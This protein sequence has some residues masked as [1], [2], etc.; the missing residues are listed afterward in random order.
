MKFKKIKSLSLIIIGALFLAGCHTSELSE[1]FETDVVVYK[2]PNCGCCGQHSA[3]M[4]DEGF[5]VDILLTEDME[6]IKQKYNIP[7]EMQ[8][9]HTAIV[10]DYFVE[11][12]MPIEAIVKLLEEKPSVDGIALP[13]M[14][15]GSPGMPGPK[16]EPFTIH[17]LVDGEASIYTV[18]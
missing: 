16:L 17:Q 4:E 14:P 2:S 3:Y 18:L 9:C 11:G 13:A 1:K 7:R 10:G 12:H 5:N 8:S 15:S 6:A